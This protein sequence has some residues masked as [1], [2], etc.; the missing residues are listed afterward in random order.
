MYTI[1]DNSTLTSVQ[2]LMG[3]IPIKNKNTIDGDVLALE[4]FVQAV[5][6]YDDVFF[7]DDYKIE[8]KD[9]RKKYFKY[10]YPIELESETYSNIIQETQALTNDFIPQ[11][12]RRSFDNK[13]LNDFFDIL[14]MNITFTWDLSS[15]VY[16]LTHKLLQEHCGV[17]IPKYS[18]LA[19]MI[20]SQFKDGEPTSVMGKKPSIIYDSKGNIISEGYTVIDKSGH[21]KDAHISSQTNLFMSG[22][23]WMDFRTTFYTLIASELGFDLTLHP[24]RNTYQISLLQRYSQKPQSSRAILNIINKKAYETFNEINSATEQILITSKL[25]MFSVWLANKTGLNNFIDNLYELK[26]EKEFVVARSL[27]ND[28]DAIHMEKG[29]IKYKEKVNKLLSDFEKQ[30][31]NLM[32]RYGVVQNSV[33]PTSSLI[34][35]YNLAAAFKPEFPKMPVFNSKIKKPGLITKL[36]NYSGFGST[37]KAIIDD[38]TSIEKLGA[39]H[40]ILTSKVV[41]D[42]DASFYNIKTENSSFANAKSYWKIPL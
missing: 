13:T 18:K 41:L 16:Y 21:E 38:L 29:N 33:N 5:L 24:I 28:L 25:P 34:K 37:F 20:F 19:D 10:I 22:L 30:M 35:A 31:N 3:E 7:I 11:V 2:R 9:A 40:D 6:F 14:K 42:R 8:Y 39:Y 4:T 1:I 26:G 27:L 15:S 12:K 36:Y 23:S 17:D 32:E